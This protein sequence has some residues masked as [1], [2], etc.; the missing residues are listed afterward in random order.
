M[1][2]GI[3]ISSLTSSAYHTVVYALHD[4][5]RDRRLESVSHGSCTTLQNENPQ[6][7]GIFYQV[8]KRPN[9]SV[10]RPN[11]HKTVYRWFLR[12]KERDD[13][14]RFLSRETLFWSNG[15][16]SPKTF[17]FRKNRHIQR[18]QVYF[19]LFFRLMG[20][21]KS[22]RGPT[23]SRRYRFLSS[24]RKPQNLLLGYKLPTGKL[25]RVTVIDSS[26][27]PRWA[28]DTLESYSELMQGFEAHF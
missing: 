15:P 24:G 2:G 1:F 21:R 17:F 14:Y 20:G 12:R 16:R 23:K 7:P 8:I 6:F 22:A 26:R 25:Y 19:L 28:S 5:H 11:R 10:T 13:T 18:Y 3:N 9:V 27:S 4:P